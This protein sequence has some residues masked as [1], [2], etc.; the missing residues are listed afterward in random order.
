[1]NS[2]SKPGSR[3]SSSIL[4]TSSSWQTAKH[5]IGATTDNY[6]LRTRGAA[7]CGMSPETPKIFAVWP[8]G[9]NGIDVKFGPV[10]R[11]LPLIALVAGLL[12]SAAVAFGRGQAGSAEQAP[13]FRG[14]VDLVD[15]GVTVVDKRGQ[16]VTGLEAGDF[17]I[18]ED[19]KLQTVRYFAL[20]QGTESA[21]PL[22]LGLLLDVSESMAAN[23]SFT[24]TA[25]IRFVKALVDAVDVTVVDFDSEVRVGRYSQRELARLVERIR[26]QKTTGMTALYDAVGVYLDGSDAL[27]GRKVMLLYTDGGD[28]KSVMRL[29]E[30][31]TLL[32]ASDVTVYAI[33]ELG[34]L[35]SSARVA[36]RSMLESLAKTTGGAAFFPS[37]VK[38]LDQVYERILA[39]VR[40]Q[41]T[42]AYH[43]TNTATDGAWRKVT[44][45]LAP[46]R[47]RELQVR[48]RNGYFAPYK[49]GTR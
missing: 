18:Y 21:P 27:E 2:I 45:T 9:T 5:R 15:L 29:S 24:R 36:A 13:V 7:A 42:L 47:G 43:S 28:T 26:Q 23:V 40:S 31:L 41:Y 10:R 14:G 8:S 30:L 4:M 48:S 11:A 39:E 25:A 44:V 12:S 46:S 3:I 32:K 17:Q 37:S 19:G 22:H 33:G 38:D 6:T 35:S 20:G 49:P 1:M 34:R 16:L